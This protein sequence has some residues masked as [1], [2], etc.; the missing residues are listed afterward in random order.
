MGWAGID[1]CCEGCWDATTLIYCLGSIASSFKWYVDSKNT[2][3]KLST[4]LR[5]IVTRRDFDDT[6]KSTVAEFGNEKIAPASATAVGSFT[7]DYEAICIDGE[8]EVFLIDRSQFNFD[9][10]V[11]VFRDVNVGV[12]DPPVRAGRMGQ[13]DCNHDGSLLVGLG[14]V[15][16]FLREPGLFGALRS[17]NK[18]NS[19]SRQFGVPLPARPSDLDTPTGARAV[20]ARS[21]SLGRGGLEHSRT[22]PPAMLLR[23]GTVRGPAVAVSCAQA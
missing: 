22:F 12:R 3:P 8:F 7:S 9:N 14:R 19:V 2:I 1:A 23:T 13:C 6:L 15:T 16:K 17:N 20:L 10:E 21:T 11:P 18:R 5:C 4:C